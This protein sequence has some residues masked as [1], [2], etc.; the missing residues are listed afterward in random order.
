MI[1][2]LP[3]RCLLRT[4]L[5]RLMESTTKGVWLILQRQLLKGIF[6]KKNLIRCGYST[7]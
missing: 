2:C 3:P 5:A 1:K 7:I 4:A 6:G